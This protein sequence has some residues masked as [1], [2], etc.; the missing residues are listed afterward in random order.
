MTTPA[1][2]DNVEPAQVGEARQAIQRILDN[3]PIYAALHTLCEL[4]IFD[5][6]ARSA[7][8]A[9]ALADWA[10]PEPDRS[11]DY[12]QRVLRVAHAH[13]WTPRT[14]DGVYHLSDLGHRFVTTSSASA[15]GAVMESALG[16]RRLG[17]VNHVRLLS[18]GG[19]Q[20]PVWPIQVI[21]R[22]L[23]LFEALY[24]LCELRIPD[25]LE[26]GPASF[27]ELH[28]WCR[29]AVDRKS[30]QRTLTR[31][32]LRRLLRI[33][34]VQEWV[35][36]D[37]CGRYQQ[38]TVGHLLIS[39]GPVSMRPAVMIYALRPW[40]RSLATM[41]TTV[42]M[43]NPVLLAGRGSVEG[44]IADQPPGA[45][46]LIAAYRAHRSAS[47]APAIADAI[48]ADTG[49]V[50]HLITIGGDAILLSEILLRLPAVN[51]ILVAHGHNADAAAR[52]LA[53]ST[54]LFG[55]WGGGSH[56]GARSEIPIR[57][58][59]LYL[60]P[61]LI[62]DLSDRDAR[63]LFARVAAAMVLSGPDSVLWIVAS[64]VPEVP[65]PHPSL[66]QDLL[67][68]TRTRHGRERTVVEY[69]NLLS[70]AGLLLTATFDMGDRTIIVARSARDR[71]PTLK[72]QRSMLRAS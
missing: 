21:L 62:H 28:A 63:D 22:R 44:L 10:T 59:P 49:E 29:Q 9:D 3:L 19:T 35:S 38:T 42:R 40:W 33:W 23:D 30:W 26:D 56:H 27:H 2:A 4:R 65:R 51:G 45:A 25:R 60:I 47:M 18:G 15:Q 48:R 72:E 61:D 69:A 52:R 66:A 39:A 55:R 37:P 13:T 24:L 11:R 31:D 53:Q 8:T 16:K 14:P 20:E 58:H 41:H 1:P 67:Q 71:P 68:M 50:R 5:R 34:R 17:D 46:E 43:G 32:D 7:A 12:L 36:Q 6:L 57:F 54:D 70:T 64:V